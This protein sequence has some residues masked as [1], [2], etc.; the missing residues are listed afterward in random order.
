MKQFNF[1]L[2]KET[3]DWVENLIVEDVY[4]IL[5]GQLV[6]KSSNILNYVEIRLDHET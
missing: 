2:R 1:N 3:W 5:Y 4:E 6:K